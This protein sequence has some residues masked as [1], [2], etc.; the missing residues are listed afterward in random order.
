[1]AAWRG[2]AGYLDPVYY[3][4]QHLTESDV[5]SF[6]VVL[7]ELITGRL[8]IGWRAT[9][10]RTTRRPGE[11]REPRGVGE[12]PNPSLPGPTAPPQLCVWAATA[13]RSLDP[14]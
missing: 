13:L 12:S 11:P 1:V 5:Y 6:G 14:P 2:G 8:P 7:L 9:A 4:K 10:G 3:T